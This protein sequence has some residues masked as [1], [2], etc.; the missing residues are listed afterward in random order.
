MCL[1]LLPPLKAPTAPS[2]TVVLSVFLS[3]RPDVDGVDAAERG[4]GS[5]V[6]PPQGHPACDEN[7]RRERG[8][9]GEQKLFHLLYQ[10]ATLKGSISIL[11]VFF[12][13]SL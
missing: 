5:A 7:H 1:L 4:G 9:T 6:A 12:V 10:K 13:L 2:L 3:A 8:E 11:Y